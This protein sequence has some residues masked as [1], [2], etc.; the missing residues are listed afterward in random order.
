MVH[1]DRDWE[2]ESDL[3]A[4]T[5]AKTVENDPARLARVKAFAERRKEEFATIAASLP[6]KSARAFNGSV[7]N[8]KMAGK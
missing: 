1:S 7:R 6:G 8:S 2:A 3:D 5:R 4:L